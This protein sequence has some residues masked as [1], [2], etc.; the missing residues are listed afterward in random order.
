MRNKS[1]II[2]DGEFLHIYFNC[3]HLDGKFSFYDYILDKILMLYLASFL[4]NVEFA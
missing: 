3:M 4:E 2:E 1:Q